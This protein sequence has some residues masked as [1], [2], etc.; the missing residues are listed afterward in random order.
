MA[1]EKSP[2]RIS[3]CLLAIN[4]S[5]MR[6]SMKE[7]GDIFR[8]VAQ[9]AG[10]IVF[11]Y[12][13]KTRKFMQYSDRSELSKYGSW[14]QDFDAA[15]INAKMIYPD[16]IEGFLKLTAKIKSGEPGTIEGIFRMRL[17]ISADYRWYRLI[18]RTKFDEQGPYEVLGRVS[19]IHN[20]IMSSRENAEGGTGHRIDMMGLSDRNGVMDALARYKRRHKSDTMFACILFDVPE[21]DRIVCGLSHAKSEEL[22]INLIRRIR[23]GYPHGTLV[24]RVGVHRFAVFTGGIT[25]LTEL[26]DAVAKSMNGITELGEQYIQQLD[27]RVL[28]AHVGID[29][30]NNY[31]GV[32]NVI[33]E[34][35]L[36]A[37]ASAEEKECGE[38]VFFKQPQENA[39]SFEAASAEP[40]DMIAEYVIGL[41]SDE[42]PEELTVEERRTHVMACMRILLEKLSVKYGFERA[43]MS[44][45]RDGRYAEYMQWN[46]KVLEAIPEGCLL[47]VEGGQSM[48]ESKVTFWEP[49]LV[50]DV[51]S[52]PDSSE[53][54]RVVALSAVRSFAQSGFECTNGVRGIVS[55]EFYTQPHVWSDEEINAFNTVKY[56][57]DFC[58]RYIEE[59]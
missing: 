24:C 33:Y 25:T 30:E 3:H 51:Y 48:V 58:A 50:S 14:L 15:M 10:D 40:E 22:L 8:E 47:H 6:I 38:I 2:A 4:R 35:A 59:G 52:Y 43:S 39:N 32:E 37:L 1:D 12:D 28:G 17:H 41:L 5:E 31:D 27:G 23:R 53:Y 42:E 34:R 19:D 21:Y 20:Y 49:Y 16:D 45:C 26:G 44:V 11:R 7:V 56:V 55:F 46:T 54:G 29:F 36:S 57:A 9:A 18:A 13:L